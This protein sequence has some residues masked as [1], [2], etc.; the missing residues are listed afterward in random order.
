MSVEMVVAMITA[1]ATAGSTMFITIRTFTDKAKQ[2]RLENAASDLATVKKQ[3]DEYFAEVTS[4]RQQLLA[5]KNAIAARG[6]L[7]E[8]LSEIE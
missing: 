1:L 2:E 7:S 5:I 8:V 4:L 6:I 3:R